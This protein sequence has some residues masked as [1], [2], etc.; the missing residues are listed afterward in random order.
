MDHLE[1]GDAGWPVEIA[2]RRM[3]RERSITQTVAVDQR[4]NQERG[5]NDLSL[6]A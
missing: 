5:P 4:G 2:H 1:A 6:V 3:L